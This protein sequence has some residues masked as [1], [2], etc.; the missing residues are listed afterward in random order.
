MEHFKIGTIYN[1]I[2]G[3]YPPLILHTKYIPL[4][5]RNPK[6]QS[7]IYSLYPAQ[8]YFKIGNFCV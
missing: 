5:L 1:S 3:T 7:K 8:T 4:P 6:L 2:L